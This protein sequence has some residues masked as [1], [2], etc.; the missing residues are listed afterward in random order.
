MYPS[1]KSEP[2]M[3]NSELVDRLVINALVLDDF[4]SVFSL[5]LSVE[6]YANTI[7]FAVKG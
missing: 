5:S 7:L 3:K 2:V 6:C 1:Q 4:E